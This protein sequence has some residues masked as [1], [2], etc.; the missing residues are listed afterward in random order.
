VVLDRIRWAEKK[1]QERM[2]APAGTERLFDLVR[3]SKAKFAPAFYFA[4]RDTLVAADMESAIKV[5]YE[6]GKPVW[7]VVTQQ[8]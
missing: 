3:P 4:M 1:M 7:R 2:D 6:G 5:A 8:G